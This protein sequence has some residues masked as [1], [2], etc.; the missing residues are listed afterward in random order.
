MMCE[1]LLQSLVQ[2]QLQYGNKPDILRLN[3]NYYRTI[4]EQLAYPDWLIEKKIKNLNQTFLG[5]QVELTS[6]VERFEI[7]RIKKVEEL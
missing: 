7:R 4:L 6:E 3:K 5:I 1:K 2:Y